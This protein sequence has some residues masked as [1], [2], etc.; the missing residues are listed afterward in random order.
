MANETYLYNRGPFV[1]GP[2]MRIVYRITGYPSSGEVVSSEG[3]KTIGIGSVTV[4][5][6]FYNFV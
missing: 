2:E 3:K 4:E 6:K 5:V 1:H